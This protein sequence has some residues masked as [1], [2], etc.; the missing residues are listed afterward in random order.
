MVKPHDES[1]EHYPLNARELVTDQIRMFTIPDGAEIADH[2]EELAGLLIRALGEAEYLEGWT[3]ADADAHDEEI[4][5]GIAPG[6]VTP[7]LLERVDDGYDPIFE[8]E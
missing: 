4:G 1:H 2:A 8:D 6:P 7:I 5:R 3:Q